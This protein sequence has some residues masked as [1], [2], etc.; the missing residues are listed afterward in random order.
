LD[1]I[2]YTFSNPLRKS[3]AS[4]DGDKDIKTNKIRSSKNKINKI[5]GIEVEEGNNMNN[6]KIVDDDN[7][8]DID[9]NINKM[10]VNDKIDRHF[11]QRIEKEL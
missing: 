10:I 6:N 9:G 11:G 4:S 7:N 1:R 2:S 3:S 8:N 5:E